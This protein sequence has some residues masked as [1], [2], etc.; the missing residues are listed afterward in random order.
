[1]STVEK[2]LP[3]VLFDHISKTHKLKNDAALSRLLKLAPTIIS[4]VRH[5]RLNV[6]A[7]IVINVHLYTGMPVRDIMAMIPE[8]GDAS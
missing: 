8:D 6:S 7:Q 4:K 3:H 2:H 1:M 5:G